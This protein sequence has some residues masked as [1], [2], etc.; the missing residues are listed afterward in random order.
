MKFAIYG[1]NFYNKGAELMLHAVAQQIYKWDKNN[2]LCAHLEI[3]TFKQRKKAKV[4]HL[5][6]IAPRSS[7]TRKAPILNFFASFIPKFIRKKYGITLESEVDI[8]LDASGFAFSDQWG[9][10]KTETMAKRCFEWKKQGKRVIFL[11]QAFGPFT[12]ERI[13]SAFI[14]ILNNSDLVFARDEV[15]YEHINN[16]SVPVNHVKI[17]PDFTNLL[18]GIEPDYISDLVGKPCIIPNQRMLDKTSSEV[19]KT[20][21]SFLISSI[22]HLL[23]KGFEPFILIHESNDFELGI[24]LKTQV[25]KPISVIKEDNAFFLKGILGKCYLVIGSRFH[26]LISSL[27]Q[28]TPCL[29]TG[30]SHKYQMLF[31][32]Y[33]CTDLLI[34][35][36]DDINKNLNRLDLIIQEPTRGEIIQSVKEGAKHQKILSQQ[37]W[38]EIQKLLEAS[39][40]K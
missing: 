19:Q 37:M 31:K 16:L 9:P 6:W 33:N 40:T 5:T 30:W 3:G 36:A 21:I 25:S 7:T 22:E 12:N 15:S 23:S 35:V 14:E 17:A 18:Q 29:G 34:N 4:N 26:G 1:V 20:Y 28:G 11:P 10:A 39:D 24:H 8:I 32:N 2:V 38:S 27:S 13:K